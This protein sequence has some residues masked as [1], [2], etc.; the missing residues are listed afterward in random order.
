MAIKKSD[1]YSSLWASCDEQR[2]GMDAIQC[3]GLVKYVVGH[4][5]AHLLE[6]THSDRFVELLELDWPRWREARREL[7]A[8]PLVASI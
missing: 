2:G 7:N 5:M 4:E 3:K 8:L 1:L 6:P